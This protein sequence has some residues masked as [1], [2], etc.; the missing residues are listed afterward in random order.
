MAGAD[1]RAKPAGVIK[2]PVAAAEKAVG[3]PARLKVILLLAAIMALNTATLAA[4]SASAREIKRAFGIGN[5]EIGLLF[6]ATAFV[7]AL[8]T[9]PGGILVDRGKRVR[10]LAWAI[11][12]WALGMIGSGL[13]P[14]YMVLLIASVF[15]GVVTALAIPAIAS[16][17]GDFFPA[18]E[19]ARIYGMIL[20]GE[21][22]GTG[23]GFLISGELSSLLGW[24]WAFFPL[25][26]P[27]AI[28]AWRLPRALPEPARGGRS[29]L[30]PGQREIVSEEEAATQAARPKAGRDRP[31]LSA[32]AGLAHRMVTQAKVQ[33]IQ[34]LVLRENPRDRGLWW[35]VRYVLK[36]KTNVLLI[37]ASALGYYF[38]A[39]VN[40]FVMIFATDH[41]HLSGAA[42]GP[43]L[44]IVGAGALA[45]TIVGGRWSDSLLRKGKITARIFVPGITLTAAGILFVPGIITTSAFIGIA[46]F[47]AAAACLGAANPSIDAARLDVMH[48]LLWG[49][50]EGVRTLL[51]MFLQAA[52]PTVFGFVSQSVFGGG[53]H[54]L[55]LTF[56]VMLGPLFIASALA[57]PARRT[58]PPDVATAAE[59]VREMD[60][61]GQDGT[62]RPAAG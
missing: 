3:G 47:T 15:L 10:L 36:V 44:L 30:Q 19:R 40:A 57:I 1:S 42:V 32:R 37:I 8:G 17:T 46:F 29:W 7:G 24:R 49:R 56:L 23:V 55:E 34:D 53:D 27:S 25:A 20:A 9:L 12:L 2:A 50:A 62:A 31:V 51:R 54:G 13:A 39:G 38:F 6:S 61:S 11:W 18:A 14:S 43:L 48:P 35:V 28:L 4:V 45:G 5:T 41:Y 33:P 58:Y 22:V 16:L 59:S 26:I 52:A 21:M 60:K